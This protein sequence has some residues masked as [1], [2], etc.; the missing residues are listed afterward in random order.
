MQGLVVPLFETPNQ[1]ALMYWC[2]MS[3]VLWVPIPVQ[4]PRLECQDPGAEGDDL[5]Q[6]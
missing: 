4:V 3:A 2:H 5:P 1:Q 6:L